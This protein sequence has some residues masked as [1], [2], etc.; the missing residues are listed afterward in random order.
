MARKQR[1]SSAGVPEHLIQ[2]QNYKDSHRNKSK[3]I[4]WLLVIMGDEEN[5]LPYLI[6]AMTRSH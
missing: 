6:K 1:V 5:G 3:T 4:F 2:Q